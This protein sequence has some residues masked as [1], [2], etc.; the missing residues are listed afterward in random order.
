M[1]YKLANWSVCSSFQR[2]GI[3]R[4]DPASL[5]P[6]EVSRFVRLDI[7]PA[8]ITWQR[9][10]LKMYVVESPNPLRHCRDLTSHA[11]VVALVVVVIASQAPRKQQISAALFGQLR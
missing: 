4:T 2:L 7:D 10:M 3:S 1:N 9:G 6:Q 8:K 5:T 11:N